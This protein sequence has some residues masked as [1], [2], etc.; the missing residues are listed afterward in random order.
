VTSSPSK[1]RTSLVVAAIGI[2]FGDI[3][4][5][6]LYAM[7][8]TFHGPHPLPLDELHVY[9]VLSL[10][11]WLVIS[12]V[13]VKYLSLMMRADN[14]GEGGS[15]ALLAL[16]QR[17]TR[18]GRLA[19]AVSV[20]GIFAAALFYGDSILTPAISVLSAVEGLQVVSPALKYAVAPVTI[21]ILALLFLVQKSGTAAVGF[22]FGPVMCLWFLVLAALGIYNIAA[23][24]QILLA[25]NPWHALVF[26]L[27]NP[28]LSFL[29]LG[30][31][32]LVLTGAEAL[33]AD[34]GHFGKQPIR[35]A[36]YGLVLPSLIINYLGQGALLLT[37]PHAVHNP[38]YLMAPSWA[39][40]P[41][42]GLATAAAVIASQAV[43]SGAFSVTRQ[44]IQLNLLPRMAILHT[45]AKAAGQIYVPFVNW[46]LFILVCLL[47]LGFHS[48]SNLAAAYGVAVTATMLIDTALLLV[49]VRLLWRWSSWAVFT[50]G[51]VFF[52]IDIALFSSNAIKI[53]HG[54]WFPLAVA[55]VLFVMLTTWM[56]GRQALNECAESGGLEITDFISGTGD[57]TRV[58][59]TAVFMTASGN[60]VPT[61]L[62]HNL[63]HN[64]V[65]H[66]RVV[67][68]TV[69]TDDIPVVPE[70]MRVELQMLPNGFYRLTLRFGFMDNQDVPKAL[71]LCAA[72]GLAFNEMDTSY[73]LNRETLLPAKRDG[74]QLPRWRAVLFA[75]MLRNATTA[76]QFFGLPPNRVVELGRQVEL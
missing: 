31:V 9:G 37:A 23:Y 17:V 63:K 60:G 70:S 42:I 20:L 44:A 6:P 76:M 28:W 33:Y 43:I 2:V 35:W 45:S 67:L 14:R 75:W 10:M 4:T 58:P 16:A 41:M 69:Q 18:A 74:K 59:G 46:M 65:L 72:R 48:S 25:L 61:A 19:G 26:W 24:P 47:I 36:W 32:V 29:A 3:G 54:G 1:A 30:S 38:F 50:M 34:M 12:V 56:R 68:L 13:T 15:L 49:V 64:K 53:P 73:F 52:A 22:L 39:L 5:S 55:C 40:I 57:V 66:D 11:F 7:K 51:V 62:L 71:A 27:D 8:E 21:G